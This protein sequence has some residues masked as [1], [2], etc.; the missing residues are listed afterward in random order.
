MRQ[1]NR[2]GVTQIG[3]ARRVRDAGLGSFVDRRQPR[4]KRYVMEG[5]VTALM[6]GCIAGLPSLREVEALTADLN[7]RLRRKTKITRRY[8][9]TKLRDVI[10]G[11][12]PEETRA[13]LVRQVKA[14]HRR[15]GLEP[16]V[17][18]FGLAAIDGKGHGKLDEW[19]HVS[20]QPVRPS[21]GPPY[22]L[23]RVHRAHLVSSRACIC[24]DQRPIP[25]TTNEIGSVCSFTERLIQTYKKTSIFEVLATDAGNASLE[26]ASLI[27]NHDLGYVLAIKQPAG[28]IHTEALRQLGHLEAQH[29]EASVVTHEKGARVTHTVWRV[30]LPGFL[31][32]THCRQ[33]VRIQRIVE[34]TSQVSSGDRYFVTNLSAGR[35]DA[36]GWMALVR[37]YW[38]CENEGH[39]TADVIWKEDA[40]RIPW[41]RDPGAI[42]ALSNLRMTALNVLAVLRRMTK[43]E[44]DSR[45]IP[46]KAVTRDAYVALTDPRSLACSG[47][48]APG[49]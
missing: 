40:K 22:G 5:L 17:L 16:E 46:W 18:P 2:R 31:N 44:Y 26:H 1:L 37:M 38:R 15:G 43:R 7:P 42:Y 36:N 3:I 19:D 33:L 9:D 29:A 6:L 47:D 21:N 28:E 39:W 27:H 4:G 23:A 25:G 45:S 48:F 24:L 49:V 8:S 11:L 35:L 10:L 20:V 30:T 12:D 13:G 41:I 32:W 34:K 14:E